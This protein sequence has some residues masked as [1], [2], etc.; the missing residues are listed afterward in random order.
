[1]KNG[2]MAVHPGAPGMGVY[3][4]HMEGSADYIVYH[5]KSDVD[6]IDAYNYPMASAA[7]EIFNWDPTNNM[8]MLPPRFSP[9]DPNLGTANIADFEFDGYGRLICAL[10]NH[11]MIAITE[12]VHPPD[13]IVVQRLIGGATDGTSHAA[14]D[15]YA[16]NGVAVDPR[17]QEIFVTD[18]GLNR[19]QVFDNQGN[20][21]R[22]FG[23]GIATNG[24]NLTSPNAI[25]IDSF[26]NVYIAVDNEPHLIVLNEFGEPIS[27]GSIDGYVRDKK[28]GVTLDNCVVSIS[29]TYREYLTVTDGNGY[30]RFD[31]VPQGSHTLIAQRDGYNAGYGETYVTG[32]Y[33]TGITLYM[34]RVGTGESGYGDISGKLMSSIDG[35]FLGG[36]IVTIEGLG[37]SNISNSYD[38]T[39]HLVG[40]PAGKHVLQILSNSVILYEQDVVVNSDALTPLGYI[41]LPL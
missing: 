18:T 3:P 14:G 17:N 19:V 13:M 37:I 24:L 12:P 11:N 26:G 30:F 31:T 4:G 28:T 2:L 36:L 23:S 34:D 41:Y 21:I 8:T 10:P 9:D 6:G 27:Y 1:M 5:N 16:P 20:F 15:F 29:S 33:K 7:V 39:F 35:D 40:V 25:E 32:G 38:G 22:M